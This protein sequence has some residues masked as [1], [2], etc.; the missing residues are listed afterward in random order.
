MLQNRE[1]ERI[2]SAMRLFSRIQLGSIPAYINAIESGPIRDYLYGKDWSLERTLRALEQLDQTLI[3]NDFI[4]SFFLYHHGAGLLSTTSGYEG[5]EETPSDPELMELLIRIRGFGLSR[6]IT[7]RVSFTGDRVP[8]NLFTVVLG[9]IPPDGQGMRMAFVANLSER[10]IRS[11][12]TAD[13]VSPSVLYILDRD[14]RFLSHP[15]A[16]RFG[17]LVGED[18]RFAAVQARQEDAGNAVV[19]DEEGERWIAAWKNHPEIGWRFISLTPERV[20]FYPVLRVRNRVILTVLL[21]LGTAV[22]TAFVLSLTMSEADRRRK[23]ALAFLRGELDEEEIRTAGQADPG[24]RYFPT[25]RFPC[26][27]AAVVVESEARNTEGQASMQFLESSLRERFAIRRRSTAEV[28]RVRDYVFLVLYDREIGACPE[29][30]DAALADLRARTGFELGAYCLMDS[31]DGASLPGAYRALKDAYRQEFLRS[32][33]AVVCLS[34]ADSSGDSCRKD[35]KDLDF[36]GLE[37][38]FRLESPEEAD[39]KVSALC[40]G[41]RCAADPDL[42][43]YTVSMLARRIPEL[44]GEEAEL[45][46]SGGAAGFSLALSRSERLDE[47]EALLRGAAARLSERGDLHGERK[48]RE[49]MERIKVLVEERLADQSLGTAGIAAEVGL[50]VA[51]LRDI[52]KKYEGTA[53]LEYIGM[54]RLERAKGLLR[55]SSLSVREVCDCAGFIS[56]SYFFTYFKKSLGLTPSEFRDGRRET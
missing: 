49:L 38:A 4:D 35:V 7:R 15:E 43:R 47:A 28:L 52:F 13:G 23:A 19:A 55:D 42:F 3:G 30:V 31:L 36:A 6:Y 32:A 46:L 37:K 1:E 51:Y 17:T 21:L 22:L 54:R 53:L 40:A 39:R 14:G 48:R 24:R 29:K 25:L 27:M 18:L 50:S 41:L 44:L 11:A 16:E 20:V 33:G 45:L 26:A 12:L 10:R 56:Y 34:L 8:R 9:S 2:E 5:A